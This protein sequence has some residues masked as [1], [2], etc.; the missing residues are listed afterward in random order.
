MRFL[1][2]TLSLSYVRRHVAKTLLTLLGVVVGVATFSSIRSAQG[3]LVQGIRSTVDRVAGKAQLQITMVGGVPEE[4]QE[5]VRE[6]PGIRATSPVIEQIVVPERGELGSLLVIGIDLLGD[7]E[8]RDYGFDG[9]DADLDDPLLFLAQPDSALF[10]RQFAEKAKLKTGET[11][12]L[13]LPAGVKRVAARGLLTP[14]GFAEAFGGNLMVVDVY[15]AQELFGRGRRFDRL[16]IR[17]TE[18][19]TIAQATATLE[20]A[21]G[22]AYRIETP[23]RR[24]EQMERVVA[25]FVAGFNVS[26]GFA[27]SIG[28]FLIFNAFNVAVNRRRR[29][30]GTLRALG[31]TPRQVQAL[32]LAEALVI[33][34]VG[35]ILGCLAGTTLS[36][37]F[38][39]MMGQT[40]ETVYGVTS[41][42]AVHLP[43]GI[44][45]ESMVLG[46]L[47]SLV[48]AW[49]PALAAS[50]ISPTEALAKGAFQAR[51]PGKVASRVAAGLVAFGCAILLALHPP[52]GGNP[53]ILSVLLLG[54]TG[55]VLLVGPL[56]RALLRFFIPVVARFAP[57]SGRLSSDALLGSPRRTSGTVMAMALSLT[58]VLGFAGYMGSTKATMTRWM[59]DA[60]TCD[61]F[62]RASANFSRP[63]FLF[64]GELREELLKVPG[65]R[66][67]ES[68]RGI[69]PLYRGHQI[70][71]GTIEVGPLLDRTNLEFIQGNAESM[72]R[73][74]TQ[75]G[76][77]TVSENFFRRYGLGVGQQVELVTPSG[78]VR[79]PIAAV[80]RDYSSDQGTVNLDRTQFL[81]LWKDDRVDIFDVSVVRGANVG[82]VR[83]AIRAKLAGRFPA[84]VST[85]QEFT[86][87]IGKAIDAFYALTRITVFL[88]LLVAFLGIVTSLLISVSERTREIGILKALGALRSQIGRSIVVEALALALTGLLLALPAG[89]LFA[90][91][92]EGAI[93][94][95][96]TGWRMP[97]HYPWEILV[98]LL[99]ALPLISAFA[100]WI[101]ARQAGRL[102]ITEAIEYE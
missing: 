77:C 96:F 98:Q 71:V 35:G 30:I 64:P 44:A 17:L 65:V 18:G 10:T 83:D 63:D 31:A 25:N 8:M 47:A 1:L 68:Y 5:K 66:A 88:A 29:D 91:F 70:L 50:R 99:V 39:Q 42:G 81:R 21:L 75:Q 100:A 57:V 24:G 43:P 7:R 51:L 74:V 27:L 16:D 87:E 62:V 19:T 6:L 11:L 69:R 15:A 76:M 58:F 73:G 102:K 79:F 80:I 26:S 82:Q 20:K 37:G 32:F 101:P 12:S 28:T 53:L 93:A 67:V 46:L 34:I 55:L 14:K 38:L 45:L 60:L 94:E 3:T 33:G 2:A 59:N 97:H 23:D 86:A 84:L 13:R 36:Q 22:P 89:N 52:F 48:G 49:G 78:T 56:S 85:R 61:L 90:L 95:F 4:V 40:T 92:M 54:G 72:R 41:S 9:Q